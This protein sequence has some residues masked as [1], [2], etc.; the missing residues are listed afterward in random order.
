R[1]PARAAAP[2]AQAVR[3]SPGRHRCAARAAAR[4]A[5]VAV[6][7]AGCTGGPAGPASPARAA[8][9]P[10]AAARLAVGAQRKALAAR[11]LAIAE[12]GNKRLEVEVD[13]LH[14]NDPPRPPP[15]H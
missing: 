4:A 7:A 13:R 10:S 6:L 15:S 5:T 3:T 14:E 1:D 2:P 8:V 12:A 9:S 11:Y